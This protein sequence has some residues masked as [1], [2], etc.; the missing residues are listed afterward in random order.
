MLYYIIPRF[1][2][3]PF[4]SFKVS[5]MLD[6]FKDFSLPNNI[7]DLRFGIRLYRMCMRFELQMVPC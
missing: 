7:Q 4:N 6:K 1:W 5:E 3:I 2:V